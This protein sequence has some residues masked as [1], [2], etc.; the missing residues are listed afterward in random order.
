MQSQFKSL[1]ALLILAPSLAFG[2]P[3]KTKLEVISSCDS[4]DD[5]VGPTF[6]YS[7]KEAIRRSA[8]FELAPNG[9]SISLA[10]VN[11]AQGEGLAVAASVVVTAADT[12]GGVVVLLHEVIYIP[13]K[14]VDRMAI[15]VLAAVDK[16]FADQA[17]LPVQRK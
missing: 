12:C 5:Q 11:P 2:Q 4:P 13:V 10:C 7:L 9:L 8:S 16:L 6:A 14:E 17:S 1:A 3:H 15:S